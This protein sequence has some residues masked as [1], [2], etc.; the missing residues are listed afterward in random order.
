MCS[1]C[2]VL[3]FCFS[4]GLPWVCVKLAVVFCYTWYVVTP[5]SLCVSSGNVC[6]DENDLMLTIC[7]LSLFGGGVRFMLVCFHVLA[8]RH[9]AG[10]L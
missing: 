1:S 9:L 10:Q 7:A 2:V 3:V 8:G 4:A 5:S 6:C